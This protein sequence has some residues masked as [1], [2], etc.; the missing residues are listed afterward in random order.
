MASR[1]TCDYCGL[2]FSG[3]G[4][5]PDDKH[6]YCCYGCYLVQRI[7]GIE[8]GEAVASWLLMRLGVGAFLSMCVMMVS[9]LLYA[10][11]SG[12]I[13]TPTTQIFKWALLIFSTPAFALLGAPFILAAAKDLRKKKLNTDSLIATGA[14]AAYGVS[15]A[16]VIQGS[17]YVYFDT[18]TMLLLIITL[19][20]LLEASAKNR[21]SK[22]LQ[23][24]IE[25][26]PQNA[27][28]MRDGSEV[29]IPSAEV[30]SGDIV[31]VRPGEHIPADGKILQGNSLVEESAFTGETH[32]RACSP[33]DNVYGGSVNCDGLIMIE[34]TA[35]GSESLLA[36]IREM[37]RQAQIQQAPAERLAE[38][39]V[40]AFIPAVWILSLGAAAY[41][42]LLQHDVEKAGMSALA[43]LV[44]ACPCALGIATPIAAC[45]AIGKAARVG[46][47]IRSGEVL[48]R[49]PLTR[50]IFFDKTGTLTHSVLKV[51]KVITAHDEIT[52]GEA[53][54]WTAALE[55]RSEHAIGRAICAAADSQNSCIEQITS[56]KVYP[57]R[58]IEGIVEMNGMCRK[59]TAGSLE[60]LS[61]E[62]AVPE[63][64]LI[65]SS[66]ECSIIYAGWDAKVRAAILISA[67]ARK[68]AAGTIDKLIK[69][70]ISPAIISGDREAPT[71]RLAQNVGIEDVF[72]EC[73]P[74]EKAAAIRKA[75]DAKSGGVA[76][77][78]DGINDAPALAE[79]DVGIAIG[80]GTDLAR[81]S[82]DVTLLGDNLKRI[83]E[84]LEISRITCR[85]I[86]QNLLW[87]FGYNLIAIML[88]FFGFVHPLIAAAAMVGSSLSVIMNSM[89]LMR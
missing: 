43:V 10:D 50:R 1:L 6:H 86:R 38:R 62:H 5:S 52:T 79:A 9:L 82:S 75:K 68:E 48:E 4:Y 81:Q 89:R 16:H 76:M 31:I 7:T 54:A 39:A 59:V 26:M 40:S 61:E 73:S 30:Q 65:Q 45:L 51:T 28:V 69:F 87:A 56:F 47:L 49:L 41:W 11:P 70:G 78:G 12:E 3:S 25:M 44:V 24:M 2:S 55:R 13:G 37:V 18:A 21:T 53:L 72:A 88:A 83:P 58:G 46:I 8:G 22:A 27:K 17:G 15:I 35:T 63:S 66:E 60:L 85:I 57:G 29:E 32:P 42:G 74:E 36:R 67:S 34:A 14:A 20:R 84:A 80:S 71:R 33:G 64:L 23:D 19:G 77:V